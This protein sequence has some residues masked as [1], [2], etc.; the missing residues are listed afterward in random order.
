[1]TVQEKLGLGITA[2]RNAIFSLV[3]LALVKGSVGLYSGSTALLADAVHT[4]MDVF[5]SLAVWIGLKVSLKSGSESF[6]YGYYKAENIVALFV[7][8][9]ILL[10]G[11]ELLR[12]GL[13]GIKAPSVIRFEGLALATS[14]FSVF[15]IYALS[16]YKARIGHLIDSQA[17]IADARHSYTDVFASLVVAVAVLGSMLGVPQLD[18]FGAVVISF[19]IFKLGLESARDAMLTLMDAWLDREANEKIKRNIEN[20]PGILALKDLKLRKSGLVV[21]GEA[22]VEI[23]GDPDLKQINLLSESVERAVRRE[24]ENLEHLTVDARP[25]EK[26][27]MRIAIPVFGKEGLSVRLSEHLGKAPYFLFADLEAKEL[28]NWKVLE[29]P[30]SD[31]EKKR[32]V[33]TVEFLLQEK[34][35]ALVLSSVGEGPFHMLR[36]NLVRIYR[37]PDGVE[38]ALEILGRIEDLEE[39]EEPE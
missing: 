11:V 18:S 29:N 14:L 4:A 16:V 38:T 12:E 39:I 3:L 23:E 20:I 30:A 24:V 7:S 26:E 34:A 21:F 22:T 27:Q 31:I 13:A 1:M 9:L 33:K 5:T 37:T 8:L 17:L 10:S 6:P 32:G 19:L 2:S 36:D 28:R 25:V 15:G 35:N